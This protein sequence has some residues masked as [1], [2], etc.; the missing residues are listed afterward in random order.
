MQGGANSPKNWEVVQS[1]CFCRICYIEI[2][3]YR[4]ILVIFCCC[5]YWWSWLPHNP[6]TH[7]RGN[8]KHVKCFGWAGLKDDNE[9]M[10]NQWSKCCY[11]NVK[12]CQLTEMYYIRKDLKH[13]RYLVWAGSK[14]EGGWILPAV[15]MTS[16][17]I[18]C[19]KRSLTT[20]RDNNNKKFNKKFNERIYM[21]DNM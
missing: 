12:G 5:K 4:M 19:G 16:E 2:Q 3:R 20:K 7:T 13:A 18:S 17:G 15:E 6:I 9:A 14:E 8:P 1:C 11:L 21:E 10:M